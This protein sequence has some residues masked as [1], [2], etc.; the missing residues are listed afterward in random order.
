MG[1]RIRFGWAQNIRDQNSGVIFIYTPQSSHMYFLPDQE[2][3]TDRRGPTKVS[4]GRCNNNW[5]GESGCCLQTRNREEVLAEDELW[6]WAALQLTGHHW[7]PR[8]CC[9]KKEVLGHG[10]VG[11]SVMGLWAPGKDH[12]NWGSV[13][14]TTVKAVIQSIPSHTPV[15]D[16]QWDC[17]LS[18]SSG[19]DRRRCEHETTA[20]GPLWILFPERMNMQ[21]FLI[22]NRTCVCFV[23]IT[24]VLWLGFFFFWGGKRLWN[25]FHSH[26]GRL[27][28]TD[29]K[30]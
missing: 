23:R 26:C 25:L 3:N 14:K 21:W 2:V 20:A 28:T 8:Q 18:S 11:F 27:A 1:C 30:A 4:R 19:R 24:A 5:L 7:S 12:H 15:S 22:Y 10:Q 6:E 29:N 17:F 9:A 13:A 16:K